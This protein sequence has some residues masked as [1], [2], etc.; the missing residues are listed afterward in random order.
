MLVVSVSLFEVRND[1]TI[2][3]KNGSTTPGIR[4]AWRTT[5]LFCLQLSEFYKFKKKYIV[6]AYIQL[7]RQIAGCLYIDNLF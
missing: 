4:P 2:Y 1:K 5:I 3:M 6:F 7:A